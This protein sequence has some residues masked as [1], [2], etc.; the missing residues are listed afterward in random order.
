MDIVKNLSV[1]LEGDEYDEL[2]NGWQQWIVANNVKISRHA[3]VK[4]CLK[5][6]LGVL[7]KN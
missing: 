2:L 4:L 7:R 3:Y 5:E 6:G 1:R